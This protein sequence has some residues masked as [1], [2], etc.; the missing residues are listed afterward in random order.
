MRSFTLGNRV[1]GA[2]APVLVI[3][4]MA[5][6]HDGDRERAVRM[7]RGAAE[8]GADALSVHVTS[9]P[10]YMVAHYGNPGTVSAGKPTSKIFE[11][12]ERIN[13][14]RPAVTAVAEAART[15][16]LAVVLMPNDLP[17][18]EFSRSL[19]PDGY[20]L[21]P[22][23]FTDED[24]VRALAASDRPVVL[25]V[26]GS[27][28]GE[29]ERTVGW[30]RD[31]GCRDLLILHGFQVYPTPLEE[32]N[33]RA[34]PTLERIFDC[35]VGLADH[36]DGG[37]EL[38]LALP[39]VAISFGAA[40]LEKHITWD[41]EERGEDFESALDPARFARFV[42]IVR[43]A[44]LAIGVDGVGPFSADV[45]KYRQVVRKRVVA[46]ADLPRGAVIEP[47]HLACKRSDDGIGP[48]DRIHLIGR[49]LRTDIRTDDPLTFGALE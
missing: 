22:A 11:Y 1:V 14:D 46:A 20:V 25:R 12:L 30:L 3:A 44:E 40:A 48:E 26:G 33:L 31:A 49:R 17:S 32:L 23:C 2:G 27:T 36:I 28:L 13:L 21:S 18:L 16:G 6:A 47:R 39:A 9:V 24:F 19:D 41:R 29:I 42:R 38:A 5:W 34:I 15:A 4:E 45:L 10:D 43:A 7:A 35:P 8:A 37:D